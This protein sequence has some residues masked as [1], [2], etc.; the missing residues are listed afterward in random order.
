[1]SVPRGKAV[2]TSVVMMVWRVVLGRVMIGDVE[3]S[4]P[5][6]VLLLVVVVVPVDVFVAASI[7]ASR[8][9]VVTVAVPVRVPVPTSIPASCAVAVPVD[10][11]TPPSGVGCWQVT[12]IH[13]REAPQRLPVQHGWSEVPQGTQLPAEQTVSLPV[14]VSSA[15]Q[16]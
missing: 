14:Q 6:L 11:E 9:V 8:T 10:V 5:V 7:P 15:Q 4:V 2:V 13:A 3:V 12:P 1:M 16:M